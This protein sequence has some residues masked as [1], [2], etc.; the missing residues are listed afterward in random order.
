MLGGDFNCP[1][2]DWSNLHVKSQAQDVQKAVIDI[3]TNIGMTQVHNEPMR[4]N[5]LLDLIFTMNPSLIKSSTNIPGISDHAIIITDMETKP[6]YQKTTP[7]KRFTDIYSKANWNKVKENLQSLE[8]ELRM[9][10]TNKETSDN[11]WQTFKRK[12]FSSLDENIPSK[13]IKSN[14]NLPWINYKIRKMIKRKQRLYNHAKKTK[15]WNNYKQCQKE[16]K[17]QTRKA[18]WD[19]INSTI[20]EGLQSNNSKAFWKY[21]KSKKQDNIGVSPLKQGVQLVTNSKEKAEIL[22]RQF[23]SV[24]TKDTSVN[25]P[26]TTKQVR[27]STPKLTIREKGVTDLLKKV[28]LSKASG[29]DNIPNRVLKECAEEL[30]SIFTTMYQHSIDTGELPQNMQQKT[31]GQYL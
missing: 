14:N 15:K 17:K 13:T 7:R 3:T 9:G 27:N 25:M 24:F 29:P 1:D 18:E 26:N 22:I 6:H 8:K 28:N 10:Y 5:N 20:N 12:L 4:E 21:I 31:I 19:Y 11:I 2:I 16:C 23:Q 30:A